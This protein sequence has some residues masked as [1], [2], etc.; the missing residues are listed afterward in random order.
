MTHDSNDNA[1][2]RECMAR[3]SFMFNVYV[4]VWFMASRFHDGVE[5]LAFMDN[6]NKSPSLGTRVVQ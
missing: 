3:R 4:D 5:L 6:V 2:D 1:Q